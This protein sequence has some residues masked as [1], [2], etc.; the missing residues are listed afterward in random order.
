MLWGKAPYA[1]PGSFSED[2][3]V[4]PFDDFPGPGDFDANGDGAS[5]PTTSTAASRASSTTA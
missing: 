4:A 2:V 3:N 1:K 5:T